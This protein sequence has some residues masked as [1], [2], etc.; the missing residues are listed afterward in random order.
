MKKI[1][2]ALFLLCFCSSAIYA[3]PLT[4]DES[5]R[6]LLSLLGAKNY[7]DQMIQLYITNV[8]DDQARLILAE[9]LSELK[10]EIRNESVKT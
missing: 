5:T 8:E 9:I 2:L 7:I 3:Q 6:K 1:L 10:N 4:K